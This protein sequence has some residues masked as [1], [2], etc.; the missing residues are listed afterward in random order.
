[1]AWQSLKK[2]SIK[3]SSFSK[4]SLKKCLFIIQILSQDLARKRTIWFKRVTIKKP[5]LKLS[6]E[7]NFSS[8][9]KCLFEKTNKFFSCFGK[10]KE[11]NTSQ[12]SSFEKIGYLM[13]F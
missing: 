8:E 12:N 1:M 10:Q 9:S 13:R 3:L 11:R 5:K 2:P 7:I 6:F 4:F